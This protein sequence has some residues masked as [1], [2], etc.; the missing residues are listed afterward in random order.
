VWDCVEEAIVSEATTTDHL[1]SHPI[2]WIAPNM[3]RAALGD[4][5]HMG[6]GMSVWKYSAS[7]TTPPVV[8]GDKLLAATT[9]R[10]CAVVSVPIPH[11]ASEKS[12]VE[13]LKAGDA[14]MLM[15]PGAEVAMAVDT[16]VEGVNQEEIKTALAKAAEKAG[17]KVS[18]KA[19]VTLVAKIG[20]GETQQLK[21][22]SLGGG[23]RTESTA[24]LTPFTAA[25]E[26]RQ[27]ATVLWTRTTENR[28]PPILRLEEGETVQDAVKRYEK[29]DSGFFSLLTLPPRILKPAV[30]EKLGRSTLKDGQWQDSTAGV[31]AV[32]RRRP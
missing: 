3:F 21:F 6:L 7:L 18:E 13:L 17:W 19:P 31:A 26:I 9:S 20:R 10:D 8:E 25:L 14:A 23:N 4:A 28:I 30:S 32:P 15:R 22:R 12:I 2:N 5:V 29:P 11:A 24:N 27:G 1:G 16:S